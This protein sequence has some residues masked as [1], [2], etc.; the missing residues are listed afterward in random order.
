M[1]LDGGTV[2]NPNFGGSKFA[3]FSYGVP[4]KTGLNQYGAKG[5]ADANM[6]YDQILRDY[7]NFDNIQ[8]ADINIKIRVDGHSEYLLEDYVK[9][10]YEMPASWNI[11]ALK[12][13]AVASRSYVLAYTNNGA[14]SICDS[15]SCQV[16]HDEEKGGRWNEAVEATKGKIMALGG[17]PIKAWYS[18]THGGIV[19]TTSQIGWSSTGWT[20]SLIDA[21]SSVN[22]FDDLKAYA[23]DKESPWFYCDWGYRG[24]QYNNT[25]WLTHD[26]TLDIANSFLLYTLDQNA[27]IHLSQQDEPGSD[28]WSS[29]KV[30]EEIRSKGKSPYA[31][32]DS[33]FVQWDSSG[34][35]RTIVI[36][37]DSYD[38]QKFK[39]L[40]NIR[41]PANIQIKPAC[42]PDTSLSCSPYALYNIEKR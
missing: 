41:A 39:N 8:D 28:T 30:K 18:S 32:I 5:R 3:F 10:I 6:L 19:L 13:Q 2:K 7:Y 25:A 27:I 23:Y 9:R 34:I 26:E 12:A 24:D 33:M 29:E 42:R 11:E 35:S 36:N 16:F 4:N 20:K 37:G 22:S 15:Q 38:A 1:S 17:Q 21:S 31:T 14:G 40:F